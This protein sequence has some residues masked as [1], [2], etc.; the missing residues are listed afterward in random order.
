MTAQTIMATARHVKQVAAASRS[1]ASPSAIEAKV[2]VRKN[3]EIRAISKNAV[4]VGAVSQ[5]WILVGEQSSSLTLIAATVS[6]S[7]C[8]RMK[9]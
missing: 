2:V 9:S 5:P 4:G 3:F 1:L 6:V 8:E 7:L